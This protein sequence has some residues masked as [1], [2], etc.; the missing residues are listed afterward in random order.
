MPGHMTMAMDSSNDR[1]LLLL[2]RIS[3]RANNDHLKVARFILRDK[4]TRRQMEQCSDMRDI[5]DKLLTKEHIAPDNT[6]LLK[7]VAT[8]VFGDRDVDK[9]I[10]MYER[11]EQDIIEPSWPESKGSRTSKA[12][13]T[14]NKKAL[15]ST[16][17]TG[18]SRIPSKF[19]KIFEHTAKHIGDDWKSLARFM[20]LLENDIDNITREIEGNFEQS[21]KAMH[22]W[23][24]Q[25]EKASS[26]QF[27]RL[28]R[29][30]PR[31]DIADDLETLFNN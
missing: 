1:F 8:Q 9:M 2:N 3:Q 4:I 18:V 19:N 26:K 22:M 20:G 14:V 17:T 12:S 30:I 16:D 21:Q 28:L 5:F 11:G 15:N 10:E 25:Q 23:W 6:E 13:S 7:H 27:K 24:N 31:N 29:R